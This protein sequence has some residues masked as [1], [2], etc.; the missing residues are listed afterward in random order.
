MPPRIDTEYDYYLEVCI[1]GTR[2][3]PVVLNEGS[4]VTPP[5]TFGNLALE[6]IAM[7]QKVNHNHARKHR[8]SVG[9][10]ARKPDSQRLHVLMV[11]K[12]PSEKL[13]HREARRLVIAT[14]VTS[15]KVYPYSSLRQMGRRWQ[16][17]VREAHV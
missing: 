1:V 8:K 2:L 12:A 11:N 10:W 4:T 14:V 16:K 17:H 7:R 5:P 6:T 9:A 3:E 13:T 15:G